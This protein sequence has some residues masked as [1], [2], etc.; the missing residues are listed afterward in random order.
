MRSNE[1]KAKKT[2]REKKREWMIKDSGKREEYD[3]GMHR[4]TTEGKPRFDLIEQGMLK[5][6]ANHMAGGAEKYGDRNWELAKSEEELNRFK[7]SA[8]RHFWQWFNGLEDEDHAS[9]VFFNIA[10]AEYMKR[11]LE[12]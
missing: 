2:R 4:D 3:S 8:Y 5:R 11:K 9:A 7:A 1:G 10:A 12:R 6:W